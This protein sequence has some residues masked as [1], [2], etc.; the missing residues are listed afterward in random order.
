MA[1]E[2]KYDNKD[3]NAS[4]TKCV[5]YK[6]NVTPSTMTTY[7]FIFFAMKFNFGHTLID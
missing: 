3:S 5:A 7:Y 6:H 4:S 2:K 1:F